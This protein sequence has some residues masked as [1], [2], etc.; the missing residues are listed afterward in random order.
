MANSPKPPPMEDA[1]NL[2]SWESTCNELWEMPCV[3]IS[4][5]HRVK[6]GNGLAKQKRSIGAPPQNPH[7]YESPNS[8]AILTMGRG[9]GGFV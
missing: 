7:L 3:Q 8:E 5:T 4:A 6:K 2:S 1:S 9:M